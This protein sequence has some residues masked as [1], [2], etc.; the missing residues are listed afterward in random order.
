MGL[1]NPPVGQRGPFPI[2]GRLRFAQ[3]TCRHHPRTLPPPRFQAPEWLPMG[4]K[5]GHNFPAI[6][7][8]PIR[9]IPPPAQMAAPHTLISAVPP[10]SSDLRQQQP[11]TRG[12]LQPRPRQARTSVTCAPRMETS[13]S[14]LA[15]CSLPPVHPATQVLSPAPRRT[16]RSR[17]RALRTRPAARPNRVPRSAILLPRQS[18][19]GRPRA[20]RPAISTPWSA[21]CESDLARSILPPGCISI[22]RNW[23]ACWST[24]E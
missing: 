10:L 7:L 11:Q 6:R 17:A 2:P 12:R 4:R 20:L 9:R 5:T 22:R 16:A 13:P 8:N 15:A 14:K 18:R 19:R 24:Y 3:L 1:A 21:P 23:A